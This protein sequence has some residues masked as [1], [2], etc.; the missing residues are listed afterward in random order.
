MNNRNMVV[1][2]IAIDATSQHGRGFNLNKKAIRAWMLYDWAN[3]A[4]ATTMLAAV[5]PIFY[6]DVAGK[7][8]SEDLAA[9]YWGY[10]QSIALILVAIIAPLLGAIAD[11]SGSKLRFL[12][13]FATFG[14]LASGLFVF[15]G[16]GDY[17]LASILMIVGMIGFS[18]G[19][20]FYDSMLIDLVPIRQ[21]DMVSR[22]DIRWGMWAGGYYLPSTF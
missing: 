10:T 5:L 16:E 22:R 3:S 12:R 6:Y 15:V 13:V 1:L 14:I 7:N 8:L 18:G 20:T 2:R 11:I 21:R 19:N 9:S 17:V 4:F